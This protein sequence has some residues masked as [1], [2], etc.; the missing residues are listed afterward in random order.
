MKF[1]DLYCGCGGLSLGLSGAGWEPVLAVDID[2]HALRLYSDNFPSHH[3]VLKHDLSLPLPNAE[4]LRE[5]LRHFALVS[6]A[7]C[8]DFS[9]AC[10][11]S[12]PV[13]SPPIALVRRCGSLTATAATRTDSAQPPPRTSP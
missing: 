6:G 2:D 9:T 4:S 7:P 11:E 1:V 8:Q 10:T 13:Y 5:S 3:P 12:Q